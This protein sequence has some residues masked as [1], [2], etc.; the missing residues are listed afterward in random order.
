MVFAVGVAAGLLFGSV[1][2]HAA[3]FIQPGKK[4]T[5]DGYL[6]VKMVPLG[7]GIRGV[8]MEIQL[9]PYPDGE[10][11]HGIAGRQDI[12]LKGTRTLSS[13]KLIGLARR[14]GPRTPV[15]V[16]GTGSAGGSLAVTAVDVQSPAS[17]IERPG[18]R[19]VR[20]RV[21]SASITRNTLRVTVMQA[22]PC[23]S[24]GDVRFAVQP[25]LETFPGQTTLHVEGPASSGCLLAVMPHP[26]EAK[27]DLLKTYGPVGEIVISLESA[28]GDGFRVH[29]KQA[30]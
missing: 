16:T 6:V 10:R 2:S 1:D 3:I 11:P 26:I 9:S 18:A 15:V 19:M 23:M 22:D 17:V 24:A 14:V 4:Y 8:R 20:L 27:L 7:P 25:V 21:L 30:R 28:A 29:W 12:P 5:L 13:V